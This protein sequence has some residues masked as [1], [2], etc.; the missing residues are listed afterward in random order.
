[1]LRRLMLGLAAALPLVAATACGGE[2]PPAAPV[3][4]AR[5]V[6][7]KDCAGKDV[8]LAKP[9]ERVVTLDGYAAQTL[10]R[11]GLAGKIVGTG[12]PAPFAAD[13]EPYRSELAKI[14][15]LGEQVP[16][17]EVA[18]AQGPDLVLTAFST[19]GGP[20]GSPKD[21]DL[22]T[23]KAAGL[24]ACMPGGMDTSGS[25]SSQALTDLSPTYDYLRKLGKVFGV[26]DRAEKLIAALEARALVVTANTTAGAK[27]RVLVLQDNPVAGQPIK[28]SGRGTIAHALISMAGG[29]SLFADVSSMHADIS[30]EQVV[31][32]DPQIIWVIT[33]YT[34]AKAKGQALVEQVKSNPLLAG[35]T[36]AR[37][38][39]IFSTSQYLVSFPSPLNL[40]GLEQLATDL[41]AGGS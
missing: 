26:P 32:R 29:Q 13:S 1:M 22:A 40:D 9:P 16:V 2:T 23:M 14:P 12:F 3:A 41:H 36:A 7:V 18:A 38:G 30:P 24:A 4:G 8:A 33:D 31:Q 20:P 25:D 10:I 39:K 5:P 15:V 21:A 37:Q 34:F 17:T 19:F 27:P 35:T 6:M 28:T 11:L